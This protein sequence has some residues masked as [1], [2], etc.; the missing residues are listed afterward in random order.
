MT[1]PSFRLSDLEIVGY[2]DCLSEEFVPQVV[3]PIFRQRGTRDRI[4]MPPFLI[5]GEEVKKAAA[6][7]ASDLESAVLR[8][9]ATRLGTVIPARPGNRL[10]VDESFEPH[11]ES[12]ETV[13]E[14]LHA[15][16][17]RRAREAQ[18]AL[19]DGRIE[20]AVRLAQ[21]AISADDGC[22][23]AILVKALIHRIQGDQAS[24][25]ILTDIGETIVPGADLRSWV[26]FFFALVLRNQ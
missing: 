20:R 10:W 9:Q 16:A 11:Y 8:G 6:V 24:V 21:A 18:Q 1:S 23:N 5:E 7:S 26:D 4:I 17:Q 22:L 12:S 13:F 14:R 25:E 2:A 3:P 19:V 15:I